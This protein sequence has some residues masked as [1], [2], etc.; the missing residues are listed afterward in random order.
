MHTIRTIAWKELYATFTNRNL[1]LI[2]LV[3]PLAL[4]LIIGLAF[5]G[6]GDSGPTIA[7]VP[8]VVVNLDE[9]IE[10][11]GMNLGTDAGQGF[12]FG[13]QLERWRV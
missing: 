3:T 9:G 5:G 7:D 2:M 10:L 13:A 11:G 4:S 6:G 1:L 12:S 8:V